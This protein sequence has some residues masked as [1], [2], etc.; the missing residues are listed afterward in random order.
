MTRSN[1]NAAWSR[2]FNGKDCMKPTN[3]CP[4]FATLTA[5][6]LCVSSLQAKDTLQ[7]DK[8]FL[9]AK[10]AWRDVT[11]FLQD[12]IDSD[13]LS[14]S[15][16]QPFSSI[17][18]DPA[19]GRVKNLIVDYRVNGQPHRLWLEEQFPVA[20]MVKLPSPDA[21]APGANPQVT[22]LMEN[23]AS[24]PSLHSGRLGSYGDLL[25]YVALCISVAALACAGLALFQLRQ[26]RKAQEHVT[27]D[28]VGDD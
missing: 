16:A 22:A 20:F 10:D 9:G 7:I 27:S 24:A 2:K 4:L 26:I 14:V 1:W 19:P 25:V 11:T 6:A 3:R 18:G 21:E 17:G 12:Q 28:R 8:A 23:I 15:I 5:V 13:V